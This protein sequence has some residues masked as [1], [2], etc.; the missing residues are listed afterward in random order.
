[1]K[2]LL[3]YSIVLLL[4]LAVAYITWDLKPPEYRDVP[5]PVQVTLPD[6]AYQSLKKAL[7]GKIVGTERELVKKYGQRIW[8]INTKD[9]LNIIDSL[10]IDTLLYSVA[11]LESNDTLKYSGSNLLN[12]DTL[13]VDMRI[14]VHTLAILEPVNAIETTVLVDSLK[15]IIPPKPVKTLL[16]LVYEYW[17]EI[18]IFGLIMLILGMQL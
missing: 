11:T 10:H 9:S 15:V 16:E 5:V 4:I 17:S 8:K 6:T 18:S 13:K 2:N 1:M 7:E 14:R 12:D 3:P